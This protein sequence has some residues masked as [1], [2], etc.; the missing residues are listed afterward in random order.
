MKAEGETSYLVVHASHHKTAATYGPVQLILEGQDVVI[1]DL[2]LNYVRNQIQSTL[3]NFWLTGKG[4]SF[5]HSNDLVNQLTKQLGAE[6]IPSKMVAILLLIY[7]Y[8]WI[9][10]YPKVGSNLHCEGS[11]PHDSHIGNFS[12]VYM[13]YLTQQFC[14]SV[15]TLINFQVLPSLH[16][17]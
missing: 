13:S 9:H 1:F 10:I 16:S 7:T 8:T 15:I 17:R 14:Y 6:S 3:P 5:T 4:L 2:Y 12:E 11:E